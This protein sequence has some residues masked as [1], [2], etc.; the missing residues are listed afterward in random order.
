MLQF[1][2]AY[3]NYSNG[4]TGQLSAVTCFMLFF[5]SLAR[6]FT[7]IQETNDTAM[8]TMYVCST[9]ANG[10]IVVQL[11]YYWN[12]DIKSKEKIKKRE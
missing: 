5:G 8:I 4:N 12:V 6:I 2:Q 1:S 11:L 10:V 7:S 3:T 9:L